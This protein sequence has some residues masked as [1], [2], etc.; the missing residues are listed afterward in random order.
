MWR[1]VFALAVGCGRVEFDAHAFGDGGDGDANPDA[2]AEVA[3]GCGFVE[4]APGGIHTCARHGDGTVYCWGDNTWGQLGDSTFADHYIPQPVIGTGYTSVARSD[5]DTICAIKSDRTPW[6]WG[7][8]QNS[9]LGSTAQSAVPVQIQLNGSPFDRVIEVEVGEH[10]ACA[11]R[12]DRSVWCWGW[13]NYGQSGMP[14]G[15]DVPAPVQ[16]TGVLADELGIGYGTSCVRAGARVDC[17]GWNMWGQLGDGTTPTSRHAPSA[18]LRG[19]SPL[20]GARMLAAGYLQVCAADTSGAAWCWGTGREVGNPNNGGAT[21]DGALAVFDML[22]SAPLTNAV[23]VGTGDRFSC[24]LRGDTSVWCWGD[25]PGGQLG[26]GTMTSRVPAMPVLVAAVTPLTGVL[27]LAV[28]NGYACALRAADV[29]CWGYN[30]NGQ[31]GTGG[32]S[33]PQLFATAIMCP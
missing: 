21:S 11:R 25:N 16:V 4:L 27:Q 14:A 22:T 24:A 12:D 9:L 1:L 33:A 8:S 2:R 7:R 6:C 23:T 20:T 29:M 28:G 5:H 26:D 3:G 17:W 15:A 13:N 19:G 32:T 18:V 10:G 31:L 30:A